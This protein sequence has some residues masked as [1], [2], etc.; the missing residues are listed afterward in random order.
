[1]L[2]LVKLILAGALGAVP[3][4]NC[5]G[6][7]GPDLTR[8]LGGYCDETFSCNANLHCMDISNVSDNRVCTESCDPNPVTE[9]PATCYYDTGICLH[10]MTDS[11]V[12]PVCFPHCRD[13]GICNWGA[14][15]HYRGLCLCQPD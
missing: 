11:G 5:D 1:M 2:N 15:F 14:P 4:N 8:E 3:I 12:T 7:Y 6:G 10:T 9:D 13:S